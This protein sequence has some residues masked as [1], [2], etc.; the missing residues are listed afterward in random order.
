MQ[1]MWNLYEI[2]AKTLK[3]IYFPKFLDFWRFSVFKV[4][5]SQN[6]GQCD[7]NHPQQAIYLDVL[8]FPMVYQPKNNNKNLS[9][10][11]WYLAP[12]LPGLKTEQG[13]HC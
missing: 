13:V 6:M 9:L 2:L 11:R 12:I 8:Y 10:S 7:Q 4:N 1:V 3:K 5:T